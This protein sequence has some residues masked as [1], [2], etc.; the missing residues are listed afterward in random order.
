MM[1]NRDTLNTIAVAEQD[2]DTVSLA[3]W[4]REGLAREGTLREQLAV[5]DTR[6]DA[7]LRLAEAA[8]SVIKGYLH[9]NWEEVVIPR[10]TWKALEQSLT[11]YLAVYHTASKPPARIPQ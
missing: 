6:L 10:D 8:D 7:A 11:A 5:R 9:G 1:T 3:K 2:G 4:C